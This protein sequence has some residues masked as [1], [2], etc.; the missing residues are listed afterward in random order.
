MATRTVRARPHVNTKLQAA[1]E[2][3]ALVIQ[4]EL[5]S[6]ID[7]LYE[8]PPGIF[9][10]RLEKPTIRPPSKKD[11]VP[12][13]PADQTTFMGYPMVGLCQG[14]LKDGVADPSTLPGGKTAIDLVNEWLQVKRERIPLETFVT[15]VFTHSTR[16][17][18]VWVIIGGEKGL[19]AWERYLEGKRPVKRPAAAPVP[20]APSMTLEEYNAQQAAR[21]VRIPAATAAAIEIPI[22][23]IPVAKDEE[24][25]IP[26]KTKKNKKARAADVC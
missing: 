9:W 8:Q 19:V 20:E 4:S 12:V 5:V 1:V 16:T 25:F 3:L 14:L 24:D 6:A 10:E 23:P 15:T 2:G 11:G 26:A 21:R 13:Y 22:A 17:L 18:S 7:R